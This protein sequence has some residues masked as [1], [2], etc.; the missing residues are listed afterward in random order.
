V[1]EVHVFKADIPEAVQLEADHFNATRSSCTR[2]Q[3]GVLKFGVFI[4]E[5][6]VSHAL[7]LG[8]DQFLRADHL[9]SATI[10]GICNA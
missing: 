5:A 6:L 4:F 8:V 10:T 2:V 3:I 9:T 1:F 7:Q